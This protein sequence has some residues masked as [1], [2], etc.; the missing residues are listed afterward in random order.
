MRR[1]NAEFTFEIAVQLSA[2]PSDTPVHT[3]KGALLW[4]ILT[5]TAIH[6]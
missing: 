6:R 1:I 4:Q 3:D 2:N 5:K